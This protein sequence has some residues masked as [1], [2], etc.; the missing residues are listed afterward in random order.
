ME[1]LKLNLSQSLEVFADCLPD[2]RKACVENII[3]IE[4][5]PHKEMQDDD[6]WT[7]E[8]IH[9]HANYLAVQEKT[10][11]MRKV[12]RRIDGLRQQ[13]RTGYK[14]SITDSDIQNA[15]DKPIEDLY[16]G[17][18]FGRKRLFGLCPFH[19]EKTPSFY[20]FPDNHFKCFGCQ[21]YGSSIDFIM[22]RDNVDFIK[23]VQKLCG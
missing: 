6:E 16:E 19:D 20:V 1:S 3:A 22:K 15:K 12:I 21:A 5:I 23:A 2:I 4:Q 9:L 17:K 14:G 7:K 18:L 10:A 8:N 11:Y 13:K